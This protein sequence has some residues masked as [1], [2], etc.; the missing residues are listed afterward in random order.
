MD[1]RIDLIDEIL[2]N[3][4]DDL[5]KIENKELMDGIFTIDFLLN[6][7]S[8]QYEKIEELGIELADAMSKI[9]GIVNAEIEEIKFSIQISLPQN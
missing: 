6:V 2:Y 4:S 5:C 1:E 8:S 9:R 3:L 7:D